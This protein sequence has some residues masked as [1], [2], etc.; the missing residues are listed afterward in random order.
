M[1]ILASPEC[2]RWFVQRPQLVGQAHLSIIT[3]GACAPF[4]SIQYVLNFLY[5][6]YEPKYSS[7][8]SP[9]VGQA[10]NMYTFPPFS[11]TSASKII[12][13]S[14]QILC[15]YLIVLLSAVF[16]LERFE[17]CIN[18]ISITYVFLALLLRS[19]SFVYKHNLTTPTVISLL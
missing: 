10:F 5:I 15:V 19:A 4:P 12:L 9:C 13:Q 18:S 14:G 16:L 6:S 2:E 7:S 11:K 3:F 1:I 17:I 8:H